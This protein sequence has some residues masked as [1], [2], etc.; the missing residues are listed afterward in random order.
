MNNRPINLYKLMILYMLGKA[1]YPITNAKISDFMILNDYA[2][3]FSLQKV[4]SELS[5]QGLIESETFRN[6]SFFTLTEEGKEMLSYFEENINRT[7][8]E[9]IDIFL[10][11]NKV[12]IIKEM[13][14]TADYKINEEG[15][16]ILHLRLNENKS[17]LL[18]FSIILPSEEMAKNICNKWDTENETFYS[19]I[20]K[21]LSAIENSQ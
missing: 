17:T 12:D 15:E 19:E 16:C 20:M 8:R 1:D 4:L 18:D 5:E 7:I 10:S 9:D 3:Y 2:S 11:E 21:L 6:S 13:T 14:A